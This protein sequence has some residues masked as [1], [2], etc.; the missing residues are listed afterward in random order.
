[1]P[2]GVL[3][4][5]ERPV[6]TDLI[7]EQVDTAREKRGDGELDALFFSGDTWTVE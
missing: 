2:L 3:R 7:R 5:V 6:Y 1:M 4:A